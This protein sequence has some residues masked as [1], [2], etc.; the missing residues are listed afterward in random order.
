[1]QNA[2]AAAG[3]D[4]KTTGQN[5]VKEEKQ[6]GKLAGRLWANFQNLQDTYQLL[7]ANFKI[8]SDYVLNTGDSQF[9]K[10]NENYEQVISLCVKQNLLTQEVLEKVSGMSQNIPAIAPSAFQGHVSTL[11]TWPSM[12]AVAQTQLPEVLNQS[13]VREEPIAENLSKSALAPVE[14]PLDQLPQ[15]S[16]KVLNRSKMTLENLIR[17]TLDSPAENLSQSTLGQAE[18]LSQSTLGETFGSKPLH[19]SE[20]HFGDQ[21]N[22]SKIKSWID[23]VPAM[24]VAP[25]PSVD[26]SWD[27]DADKALNALSEKQRIVWKKVENLSSRIGFLSDLQRISSVLKMETQDCSPLDLKDIDL[28]IADHQSKLADINK[29]MCYGKTQV[30]EILNETLP[31]RTEKEHGSYRKR[32][33]GYWDRIAAN[34]LALKKE[35]ELINNQL[36]VLRPLRAVDRL[37]STSNITIRAQRKK[38]E[39]KVA[40]STN[41][42]DPAAKA[43]AL[44]RANDKLAEATALA[45]TDFKTHNKTLSENLTHIYRNENGIFSFKPLKEIFKPVTLKKLDFEFFVRKKNQNENSEVVKKVRED[46]T[47]AVKK[48]WDNTVKSMESACNGMHDSEVQVNIL[49][50]SA[51]QAGLTNKTC[52]D[53]NTKIG[54]AYQTVA[55]FTQYIGL[56][57]ANP[58]TASVTYNT[59]INTNQSSFI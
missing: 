43:L 17:S 4:S 22:V 48:A 21:V 7:S 30:Q 59:D 56:G 1:M 3:G 34:H 36:K 16:E 40:K 37:L 58:F 53:T 45:L 47:E 46:A 13:K 9:K 8:I 42:K 38:I 51:G 24:P 33:K 26:D 23:Q 44:N 52:R 41:A 28:R 31:F 19:K 25:Q 15:I 10:L 29:K 32:L 12:S 35:F 2:V 27:V 54:Y 6:A 49:A 39:K 50:V 18:D 20:F 14:S 57:K 5:P 11:D 55:S